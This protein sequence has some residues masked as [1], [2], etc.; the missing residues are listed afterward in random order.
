MCSFIRL[1]LMCY[2]QHAALLLYLYHQCYTMLHETMG[3][4]AAHNWGWENERWWELTHGIS[5]FPVLWPAT[6]GAF[7][8]GVH[9]EILSLMLITWDGQEA[10]LCMYTR[11]ALFHIMTSLIFSFSLC[12]VSVRT[13]PPK[14]FV[15]F[16]RINIH[17]QV[18][19]LISD[20]SKIYSNRQTKP[21]NPS[22]MIGIVQ[23]WAF[24][25]IW[26][27]ETLTEVGWGPH[28]HKQENN[29]CHLCWCALL[30]RWWLTY[31]PIIRANY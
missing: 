7:V 3:S 24:G 25:G 22:S 29:W 13:F 1:H 2:V 18:Q 23:C 28:L 16:I 9:H 4:G 12:Y 27:V 15:N 19:Q 20:N 21:I 11:P 8:S 5:R 26:F 30:M 6:H 10:F 31:T 14:L 17:S